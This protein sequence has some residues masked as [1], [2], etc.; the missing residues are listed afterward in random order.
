MDA[1]RPDRRD[2]INMKFKLS[3]TLNV[4]YPEEFGKKAK[5]KIRQ[6]FIS[7][8]WNLFKVYVSGIEKPKLVL[9]T[10]T[11]V[12]FDFFGYSAYA[13]NH[14]T[15]YVNDIAT[16]YANIEK[17]KQRRNDLINN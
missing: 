15:A 11:I 2:Q 10:L 1:P 7:R 16:A 3:R 17:E 9:G 13:Y 14:F 6:G 4:L 5:K 12:G 8:S